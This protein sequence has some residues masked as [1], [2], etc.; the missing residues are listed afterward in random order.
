MALQAKNDSS[1][2]EFNYFLLLHFFAFSLMFDLVRATTVRYV[3]YK[4]TFDYNRNVLH[5]FPKNVTGYPK[6]FAQFYSNYSNC[7]FKQF[8]G[9]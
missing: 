6:S 2:A 4:R 8:L 9:Y 5:L 1:Y 7:K 3:F